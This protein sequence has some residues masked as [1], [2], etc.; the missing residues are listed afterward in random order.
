LTL[1]REPGWVGLW[2][3]PGGEEYPAYRVVLTDA[4]GAVVFSA[5]RLSENDLGALFVAL[6]STALSP[7]AYR[8]TVDG[9]GPRGE[10]TP[11]ARFPLRIVAP[12]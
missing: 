4:K 1:P 10:A 12:R 11:V 5:P 9:L 3:E 6:H 8:L 2:V 7:G